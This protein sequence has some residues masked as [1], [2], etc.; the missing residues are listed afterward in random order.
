MSPLAAKLTA[1]IERDGPIT[2]ADWMQT[3]LADPEHG[4]YMTRDPLG[5]A[6]DF[7]T[8]PEISQMFGE[9][10]GLWAAVVHQ[11]MGSPDTV[12]LIECGPGRGTLMADALRAAKGAPDFL[13]AVQ[14]H[15]VE[16]SPVLRAAQQ[17][18]LANAPVSVSWHDAIDEV[19]HGPSIILANEFM[20][21]LPVRQLIHDGGVWHERRIGI[22]GDGFAFVVGE[23][24]DVT[25]LNIPGHAKDGDIFEVSPAVRRVTEQIAVRLAAEGGAALLIDYGHDAPGPPSLGETLQ[26]VRKHDYADP[27]ASP[28]A[29]DL[30]AHVDFAMIGAVAES[31]GA[32]VWGPLT[33]G[34]LLE[35]LGIA[36]RAAQLLVS[37]DKAQAEDIATARRRLVDADAMGRLFK[38]IALTHPDAPAPPGFETVSWA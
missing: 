12:H 32:R 2:L 18:A 13:A 8:A 10:L 19:P 35:R 17:A 15:M 37:A 26:A 20:D 38:A 33:Q 25:G 22:D 21:A 9:L 5:R 6:G 27:L 23:V 14:V 1:R 7:T 34:A 24:A 11:Q 36:A 28:G 30:T 16:T 29:V 31:A 3:C 4:Y